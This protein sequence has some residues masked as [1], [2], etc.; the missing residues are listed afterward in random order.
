MDR[1]TPAPSAAA[2]ATLA[3]PSSSDLVAS[4]VMSPSRPLSSEPRIVSGPTQNTMLAVTN[5]SATRGW[6]VAAREP[7]LEP[8]PERLEPV[9]QAEPLADGDTEEEPAEHRQRVLGT[10]RRVREHLEPMDIAMT[11]V[12]SP[13][14]VVRLS[15]RRREIRAAASRPTVVPIRTVAALSNVPPSTSSSTRAWY[16]CQAD[17]RP[18]SSTIPG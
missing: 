2:N 11:I 7:P 9:V 1:Y 16:G 4:S 3:T 18:A 13:S 8:A 5:A 10:R 17:G 12:N 6:P 14:P 15:S